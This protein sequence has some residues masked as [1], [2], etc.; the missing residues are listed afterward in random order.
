VTR[1]TAIACNVA[2]ELVTKEESMKRAL[3]VF[4]GVLVLGTMAASA[5]AADCP[6]DSVKVGPVCVDKYEASVW[7]IYDPRLRKEAQGGGLV[8]ADLSRLSPS[9]AHQEGAVRDDYEC[10]D[11][12]NGPLCDFTV[13]LSIAGVKPS[14]SITWFQAQQAC[15]GAGKRLLTNAEWQMAA[16]RTFDPGET[17]TANQ[18][19]TN[20]SGP[21]LTG[22]RASCVSRWGVFDL[23]GNVMEWVA[24]WGIPATTN[25]EPLYGTGDF[26]RMTIDP[27]YVLTF[28]G[29]GAMVRGG[30]FNHGASAGV[31]AATLEA[32]P[33]QSVGT[34]GFR[35]VR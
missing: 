23:V 15:A 26:N 17:P 9:V 1:I 6:P 27:T 32:D 14:A 33:S 13:A 28:A 11:D 7:Q 24:D 16:A 34:L 20:S 35:C 10:T 22:S 19:N 31:F 3:I 21:S 8:L 5:R 30:A 2:H 25:S 4:G 12:G 29:P 18:C